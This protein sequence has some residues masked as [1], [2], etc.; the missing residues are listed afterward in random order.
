MPLPTKAQFQQATNLKVAIGDR[1]AA[2]IILNRIDSLLDTFHGLRD[3]AVRTIVLSKIWFSTEAWLKKA[4]RGEPGVNGRRR[5]AV[6]SFYVAVVQELSTLT[7][8]PI[9]LLPNWLA[10]TFGKA[11]VQHGADLDIKRNLADY[12]SEFDVAKFR[13]SFRGGV[14]YQ[15]KWWTNKDEWVIASSA[16]VV[17]G[18]API[19]EAQGNATEQ[20][21]AAGFS[22]YVLSQ[23]GDFYTGPH[24]AP[25]AQGENTGRYHSSYFGGE[26]V[27][28]AGEIK[29]E[30]GIVTE[31][32]S[33]SGHYQ[34]SPKHMR[35]AVE[36]LA[37][38]GVRMSTLM[39]AAFGQPRMRGSEYLQL[40][41]MNH[42]PVDRGLGVARQGFA[43][44]SGG[45][46]PAARARLAGTLAA[47][48][49][50][51]RRR[52]AFDLFARHLK[53]KSAG[54]HGPAG[55]DK[56]KECKDVDTFWPA[57]LQFV[58]K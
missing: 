24:F 20:V 2:D 29:I 42:A 41:G 33:S 57:Y 5:P 4:D 27:L 46:T 21:I 3:E 8:V 23:G 38:Q 14:A 18:T 26:P 7:G 6:Y 34:P 15:K 48:A 22:G 50:E 43:M 55:R 56:C 1:R 54:G 9:N 10:E 19:A 28:S 11:M 16:N 53:P 47:Q 40:A 35:M 31:I 45:D 36:T 32:N 39:V 12:L 58:S 44:G 25:A 51:L 37:M 49:T 52:A 17:A 30:N 13:L